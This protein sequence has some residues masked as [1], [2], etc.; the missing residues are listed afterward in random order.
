[1]VF[2]HSLQFY[3]GVFLSVISRPL[4][5]LTFF[6]SSNLHYT[7]NCECFYVLCTIYSSLLQ[8]SSL[9]E[10]LSFDLEVSQ[11]SFS[12]KEK[13]TSSFDSWLHYY[14]CIWSEFISISSVKSSFQFKITK[15]RLAFLSL[16]EKKIV[17]IVALKEEIIH[18]F[19]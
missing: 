4:L 18:T 17:S 16:F 1:M 10:L 5:K 11:V 13:N 8:R 9:I 7:N 14:S 19:I 15:C 6:T 2:H 3:S 12:V